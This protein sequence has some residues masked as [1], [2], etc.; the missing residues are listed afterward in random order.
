[1][2]VK[3]DI[4]RKF[5]VNGQEYGSIDE[6]PQEVRE[7]IRASLSSGKVIDMKKRSSIDF[8]GREYRSASEMP[9]SERS[10]YEHAMRLAGSEGLD[11][12]EPNGTGSFIARQNTGEQVS[13]NKPSFSLSFSLKPLFAILILALAAA[14]L[15][16]YFA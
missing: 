11:P 3:V 15:F 5:V 7:A 16:F 14:I 1:M 8:N 6:L 13:G 9:P 12:K 2:A 4:T 10:I